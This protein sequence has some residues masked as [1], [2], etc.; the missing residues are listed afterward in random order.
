MGLLFPPYPRYTKLYTHII[1]VV[2][3][4]GYLY[5]QLI[6]GEW[7]DAANGGTWNLLNPATEDSL[8]DIPFGGAADAQAAIDAAARAFPAWSRKT[9]YERADVLLRAAAWIRARIDELGAIT[10]EECGK[11]LRESMG[12]WTTAANLFEWYAEEGKRAYGRIIPARKA[13]RRILV[14]SRR[15]GR[16]DHGV[17]FPGL[18]HCAGVG[19]STRGGLYR[20]RASKRIYPAFGDALGAGVGRGWRAARRDQRDQR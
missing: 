8:G 2:D 4:M 9:P 19:G 20:R 11:P 5:K 18:Q 6:D 12:E 16:H 13:D 14:S 15:R 1:K 17:E 10:T 3:S 7:V